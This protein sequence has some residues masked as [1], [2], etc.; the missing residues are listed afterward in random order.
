MYFRDH[1]NLSIQ[2]SIMLPS[3]MHPMPIIVPSSDRNHNIH[4]R[5][6]TKRAHRPP[7]SQS[8]PLCP[9][10]LRLRLRPMLH[11]PPVTVNTTVAAYSC[12]RHCCATITIVAAL[13]LPC[14]LAL[15]LQPD[16]IA[17]THLRSSHLNPF[18][19]LV[20]NSRD[21]ALAGGKSLAGLYAIL[22]SRRTCT[23]SCSELVK[24]LILLRPSLSV[25]PW[26][27]NARVRWQPVPLPAPRRPR[28]QLGSS[29][30]RIDA[31][32]T[33]R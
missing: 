6:G 22:F 14:L 18:P 2:L 7:P 30:R 24:L 27:R 12:Y 29:R 15:R 21:C 9:V 11:P 5:S 8:S 1:E 19:P 16:H 20:S 28:Q 10:R 23:Y 26:K 25:I 33:R 3:P 17:S 4:M 32:P 13:S 31:H